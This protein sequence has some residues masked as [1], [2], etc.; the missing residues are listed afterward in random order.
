[1]VK[2]NTCLIIFVNPRKR[3]RAAPETLTSDMTRKSRGKSQTLPPNQPKFLKEH[4]TSDPNPTAYTAYLISN[5]SG[6]KQTKQNH[7][8]VRLQSFPDASLS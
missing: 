3:I 6:N 2:I 1:M 7:V 5:L 4:I 8:V